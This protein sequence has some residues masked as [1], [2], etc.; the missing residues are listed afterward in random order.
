M[1]TIFPDKTRL[2]ADRDN[3]A[4]T[5]E[6]TREFDRSLRLAFL[7]PCT[8]KAPISNTT[9]FY[10][11]LVA[12][13]CFGSYYNYDIVVGIFSLQNLAQIEDGLIP[14]E[15]CSCNKVFNKQFRG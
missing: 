14:A 9:L 13:T 7:Y 6:A 4:C 2:A 1:K 5:G 3:D 11:K 10:S 8:E 15:A 12:A